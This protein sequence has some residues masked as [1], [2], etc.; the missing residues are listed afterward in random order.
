MNWISLEKQV[1]IRSPF[2]VTRLPL[3]C[4]SSLRYLLP[5]QINLFAVPPARAGD[6]PFFPAED[7]RSLKGIVAGPA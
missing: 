7:G 2:E 6:L 4:R 1:D 3:L 5:G